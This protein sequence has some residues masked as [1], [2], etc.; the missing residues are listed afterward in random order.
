MPI[1]CDYG[2]G[3]SLKEAI[4]TEPDSG[5]CIRC[6]GDIPEDMKANRGSVYGY[7]SPECIIGAGSAAI[8]DWTKLRAKILKRDGFACQRCGSK[9]TR[10]KM[11]WRKDKVFPL[12]VHHITPIMDGGPKF[13]ETNCITLCHD[14]HCAEHFEIAPVRRMHH[15]LDS[16]TE[17]P[18]G[19]S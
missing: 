9:E 16:F 17:G 2:A 3:T 11:P 19:Q 18:D 14:C 10:R 13:D 6:G 12:E 5:K 8:H 4:P 15:T 1:R 7:C